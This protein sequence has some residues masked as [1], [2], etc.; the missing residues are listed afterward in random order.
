MKKCPYCAEEIQDE[1]I[2]CRFCGRDL[3]AS[4]PPATPLPAPPSP[5][6]AQATPKGKSRSGLVLILIL[7]GVVGLMC[8]AALGGTDGGSGG[9]PNTSSPESL[10]FTACTIFIEDQLRVDSSDAQR[11]LPDLVRR[12]GS[13][14]TVQVHYAS[15]G[16]TYECSI[17]RHDDGD[18]ELIDL[19]RR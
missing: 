9:A 10:A 19:V 17:L 15:V 18:M 4:I 11:Y 6:P 1:A 3:R 5:V 2:V 16:A 8:L 14:F 12:N 13:L 7:L